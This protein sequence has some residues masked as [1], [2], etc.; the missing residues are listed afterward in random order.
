MLLLYTAMIDEE[1]DRL[2]F[3]ELYYTYRKQMLLVA[4]RILD[5]PNEAEDAVQLALLGIARQIRN[6]PAA[7]PKMTRAYVLTAA[8]NA[9]LSLLPKLRRQRE[10]A[11]IADVNAADSEDLFRRVSASQD[12]ALL[13]RAMG[14]LPQHYREVLM[15]RYVQ[16]LTAPQIADLLHRTPAAVRQQLVRGRSRLIALCREEG[17]DLEAVV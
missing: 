15:L 3:E 13:M 10:M 14:R 1:P 17:M 2:R 8:R 11:D 9:A 5:D 12:Y 7:D 4:L 6:V 16:D